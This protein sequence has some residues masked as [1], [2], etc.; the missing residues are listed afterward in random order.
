MSLILL[1]TVLLK[2]TKNWLA[3]LTTPPRNDVVKA[4]NSF[5]KTCKNDGNWSL[6]DRFYLFAQDNQTNAKISIANPTSTACTEVNSPTWTSMQGYTGK[7]SNM[8]VNTNYNTSTN[9]VNFVQ[10]SGSMGVYNRSNT[11][12]N[13]DD[14]GN[15]SATTTN[16]VR[17][18]QA[19]GAQTGAINQASSLSIAQTDA[20]GFN[21]SVRTGAAACALWK[22]GTQVQTGSNAS[23]TVPSFNIFILAL[24]N[25]G[26]AANFSSKQIAIA[27]IGS[28][29]INQLSFYNANQTLATSLGFNV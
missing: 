3:S 12:E 8:S 20:L 19:A 27:F 1:D 17:S 29:S 4:I 6:L 13:K 28:G 15:L 10:D 24:N 11:A 14:M 5:I 22:N 25:V 18:R 26:T 9:G 21:V 2:E 7:G 23:V 16:A